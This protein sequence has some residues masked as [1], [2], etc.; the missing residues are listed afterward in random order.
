MSKKFI[1]VIMIL[2]KIMMEQ[3]IK[4]NSKNLRIF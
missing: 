4:Y 1:N 2:Q 3:L